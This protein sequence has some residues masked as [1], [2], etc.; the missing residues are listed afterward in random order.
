MTP[1]SIIFVDGTCIFCNRLVAF[2]LRRDRE[3]RFAFA[4]LQGELA[5]TAL[6]RH[7]LTPDIDAIYL[8]QAHGSAQERVLIDGQAGREIWPY[9][10]FLGFLIR[11]VPLPLLNLGYRGFARIRY[12]LFGQ[13]DRCLVPTAE[14][15]ARFVE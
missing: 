4:H 13:H 10:L 8:V 1:R 7:G 15:R 11:W 12:K 5:R 14:Q 9:V 6:A 3:G 2:I